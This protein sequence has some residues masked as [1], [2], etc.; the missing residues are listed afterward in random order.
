MKSFSQSARAIVG[1]ILIVGLIIV[2]WVALHHEPQENSAASPISGV[3]EVPAGARRAFPQLDSEIAGDARVAA[4]FEGAAPKNLRVRASLRG[5][6]TLRIVL[7]R[8]APTAVSVTYVVDGAT[9]ARE[10]G[11]STRETVQVMLLTGL[12]IALLLGAYLLTHISGTGAVLFA[13]FAK[14]LGLLLVAGIGLIG[15]VLAS[16]AASA[17]SFTGLFTLLGLIAGYL[18]GTRTEPQDG[19]IVAGTTGGGTGAATGRTPAAPEGE[20][21]EGGQMSTSR[22]LL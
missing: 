10:S 3:A 6:D 4:Q 15:A 20:F 19:K 11:S 7:N 13:A 21:A 8:P 16:K 1:A 12:G 9:S 5:T 2:A 14:V 18:A 22:A 17:E